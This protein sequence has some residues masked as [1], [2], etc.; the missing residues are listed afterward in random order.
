V[1]FVVAIP[2]VGLAVAA[3][4]CGG[5]SS[6]HYEAAAVRSCLVGKNLAMKPA[7]LPG[8]V[9]PDGTEGN[10]A[11]RVGTTEVGLAFGK[12]ADEATNNADKEK[13]LAGVALGSSADDYVRTKGNVAY[14]V[15][16][17]DTSAFDPV[18]DCLN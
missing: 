1:R 10:L 11:V 14:W 6:K 15:T 9:G 5:G 17:T 12:D 8:D 3:A 16:G 2:L 18:E 13:A 7:D 4:G